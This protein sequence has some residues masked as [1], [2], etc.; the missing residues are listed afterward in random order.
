MSGI[1]PWRM[2]VLSGKEC[3]ELGRRLPPE[4]AGKLPRM[5]A[6]ADTLIQTTWLPNPAQSP[7]PEGQL[8]EPTL[9]NMEHIA[10]ASAAIQNLLLAATEA[11]IPN[12]WS[13]GGALLREPTAYS[14]LGI[15]QEEILLGSLFLFPADPARHAPTTEVVGSKLRD[16]RSPVA[17][18]AR[19]VA[20][21]DVPS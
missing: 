16:Q 2:Y 8:F 15:P 13:S 5:L 17:S 1:Q 20:L 9:A 19:R 6:S 21:Q 10:A 12:Y 18:W 7:L 3:R 14:W 11:G 4:R